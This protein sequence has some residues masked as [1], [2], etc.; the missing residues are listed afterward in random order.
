MENKKMIVGIDFDGTLVKSQETLLS[1]WNE[2]HGTNISI[3][4]I[5][6]WDMESVLGI[7]NSELL[8]LFE[9]VWRN[10]W[11]LPATE[12]DIAKVVNKIRD[13]GNRRISII[14]KRTRAGA[15]PMIQWLNYQHIPYDDIIMAFDSR[16]KAEFP[17]DVLIDDAT[18]YIQ[19]I[20]YPRVG[21]LFSQPWNKS[22]QYHLRINNLSE[23]IPILEFQL[24]NL[25]QL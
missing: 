3:N 6:G 17:F 8:K 18:Q 12:P 11:D 10:Y 24:P 14:S 23:S 20:Q 7:S 4:Q 21:I 16:S 25:R 5:T 22:F 9:E 13:H 19:D 15:I 2:R 1:L